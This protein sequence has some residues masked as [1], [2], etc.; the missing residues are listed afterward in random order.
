MK[1][2]IDLAPIVLFFIFYKMY[3]IY[4][5][6]G[7]LIAA[8]GVQNIVHY[9]LDGKFNKSHLISFALLFVLGGATLLLRDPDFIKWKVSVVNWLFGVILLGNFFIGKELLIK[10]MMSQAFNVKDDNIWKKVNIAWIFFFAFVGVLNLFV[11]FNYDE[12]TWVNFKLFGLTGL[13]F[14][15]IIMQAIF[16]NKY[17]VV[18]EKEET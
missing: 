13:M 7:A 18:E 17:V 10:K 14:A 9:K 6:T 4:V 3:D 2:L 16:L 15:F 1:T 11:A 5:A 12:A 8:V